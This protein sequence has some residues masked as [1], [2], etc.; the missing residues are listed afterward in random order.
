MYDSNQLRSLN[1]TGR[2]SE[3]VRYS[4]AGT[5][6][7]SRT[8][9]FGTV[10]VSGLVGHDFFQNNTNLDR[11]H[12]GAGASLNTRAGSRCSAGFNGNYSNRQNGIGSSD[13][14]VPTVTVPSTGTPITTVPVATPLPSTDD[15]LPDD[16]GRLIDNRQISVV[17]GGHI[18]CGLPGGRASFGGAAVRSTLDNGSAVRRFA[19]SNSTSYSLFAGLGVF[20]PGQLQVNGSYSTID[21]PNRLIL[22]GQTVSPIG[23]NTGVKIYRAGLS[24]SRP[25]GARISGSVGVSYLRSVPAGGLA[26]YSAPAYDVSLSYRATPRLS[27]SALGSR[28]VLS[29]TSAGALFRVVDLFQLTTNFIV[30]DTISTHANVGL[31]ANNYHQPFAIPG[32]V[33]RR[34]D[35]SKIVGIGASY[36]PR[37]LYDVNVQVSETFRSSNPSIYNYNSTRV[38]IS[39]SVHV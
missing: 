9:G 36:S 14:I 4:P 22:P 2:S 35:S 7:Y 27:F 3:D 24:Y 32:E 31:T 23:L 34:T 5:A 33:E 28:S 6:G 39:L 17:Y 38:S 21:Y 12:F 29:S 25:I 26:P 20:R 18:N 19:N 10:A 30:S 8:L 37:S 1:A 13:I 15:T 16:V 11:N